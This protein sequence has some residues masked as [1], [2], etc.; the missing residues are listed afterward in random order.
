M[1]RFAK[2]QSASRLIRRTRFAGWINFGIV[3][4]IDTGA[5]LAVQAVAEATTDSVS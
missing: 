2:D 4:S 1:H 5:R 3:G